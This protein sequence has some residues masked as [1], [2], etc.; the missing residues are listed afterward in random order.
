MSLASKFVNY[1]TGGS[2]SRRCFD[3]TLAYNSRSSCHLKIKNKLLNTLCARREIEASNEIDTDYGSNA[4]KALP[5]LP[6]V[7]IANRKQKILLDLENSAVNGDN[8][9]TTTRG[10]HQNSLWHEMRRVDLPRQILGPFAFAEK[11]DPANR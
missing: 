7:D 4:Q 6:E 10:Q 1:S 2:F 9:E 11:Q 5:N 3:A 8:I